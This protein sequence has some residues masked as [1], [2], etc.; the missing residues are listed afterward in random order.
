[1]PRR[2]I[3]ALGPPIKF[4]VFG[5]DEMRTLPIAFAT[6]LA[7]ALPAGAQRGTELTVDAITHGAFSGARMPDPQWL[8]DGS[9]FF[10]LRP[11][12]DG[13]S[14]I[15]RVNAATGATTVVAP[16]QSLVSNGTPLRV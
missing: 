9:A 1:M 7:A 8:A 16:A 11:A 12:A 14:D 10:D 4:L 2:P 5:P 15:V 3:P 6:L 13:G